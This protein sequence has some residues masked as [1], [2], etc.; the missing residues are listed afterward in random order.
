MLN[1]ISIG[2]TSTFR[3]S[4]AERLILLNISDMLDQDR[5][6][7]LQDAINIPKQ[8]DVVAI[9]KDNLE[10]ALN[11]L[12]KLELLTVNPDQSIDITDTGRP[13]V[14]EIKKAEDQEA[15]VKSDQQS[16]EPQTA[17][18]P[19]IATGFGESF[20]LIRDLNDLSKLLS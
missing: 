5:T 1:E 3:P 8:P 15:L 14:D 6:V 12:I 4:E 19:N 13:V 17:D 11:Q 16:V 18:Q 2:N 20:S 9:A 10:G 7:T